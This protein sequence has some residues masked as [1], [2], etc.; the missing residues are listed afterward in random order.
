MAEM[1]TGCMT[2]IQSL[3]I[4]VDNTTAY[5]LKPEMHVLFHFRYKVCFVFI[6]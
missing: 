5:Y 2:P 4:S 1:K 3:L 6:S